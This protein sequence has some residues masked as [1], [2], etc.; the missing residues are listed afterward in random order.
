MREVLAKVALG[1]ADAGFVYATDAKTVPGQVTVIKCRPG[2]SRRCATGSR[3]HE[4]HEPDGGAGVRQRGAQQGR[5]GQAARGR[6]PA[7]RE[8][9]RRSEPAQRCSRGSSSRP[10]SSRSRSS[11]C[12]SS[13][14]S[15]TSRRA[16]S[17]D[18][19][20]NPVVTDALIVTLKTTLVAQALILAARHAARILPRD[21]GA[22]AAARC[23]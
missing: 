6:L 8:A 12:R 3:R 16:R 10:R 22:S 17:L 14:S 15:P 5:P 7:A 11:R 13:R 23:S 9:E 21:A 20:S 2:R 18:Q 19:L 1:Q 4:Q